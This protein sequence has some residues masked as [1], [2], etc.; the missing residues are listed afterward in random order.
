MEKKTI[1]SLKSIK[2]DTPPQ[3]KKV[4][5]KNRRISIYV[6]SQKSIETE[7]VFTKTEIKKE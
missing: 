1:I 2:F 5:R 6:M 7:V 4:Q 3:K